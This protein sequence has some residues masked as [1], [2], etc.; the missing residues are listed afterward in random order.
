M[1]PEVALGEGAGLIESVGRGHEIL[2]LAHQLDPIDLVGRRRTGRRSRGHRSAFGQQ[3][4]DRHGTARRGEGL[5]GQIREVL[6]LLG[7]G[8][9]Q[10]PLG[11]ILRRAG[12]RLG[13]RF[14]HLGGARRRGGESP[15]FG[16][17]AV[18][19]FEEVGEGR[20]VPQRGQ[21]PERLHPP[22]HALQRVAGGRGGTERCGRLTEGGGD[23]GALARQEGAGAGIEG[24]GTGGLG[25]GRGRR[26]GGPERSDRSPGQRLEFARELFRGLAIRGGPLGGAFDQACQ[27][28]DRA[29]GHLLGGRVPR[30]LAITHRPG[31][32]LEAVGGP[33]DRLLV[34]HQCGAA[35]GAGKAHQLG[36]RRG[37]VGVDQPAEAVDILAR[38]HGEIVQHAERGRHRYPWWSGSRYKVRG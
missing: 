23:Q 35:E 36:G 4:R 10:A 37:L 1:Q 15:H 27:R 18:H 13:G 2:P 33:G 25:G 17:R 32:P 8:V 29:V 14:E 19:R 34:G 12:Q 5:Q 28:F 7:V 9:R 22:E 20:K 6:R 30:P 21:T 3:R 26:G 31:E 16:H 11:D 24:R 38:L